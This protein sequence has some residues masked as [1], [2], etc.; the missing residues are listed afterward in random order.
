MLDENC[1]PSTDMREGH[2]HFGIL[3]PLETYL[4]Q[5][6]DLERTGKSHAD[7]QSGYAF[8]RSIAVTADTNFFIMTCVDLMVF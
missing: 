3:Q 4:A 8:F 6:P 5:V 1:L 2:N 7:R